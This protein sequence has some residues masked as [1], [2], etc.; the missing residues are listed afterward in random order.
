MKDVLIGG[1]DVGTSGCK[2]VLYDSEGRF[3]RDEYAEYD[4]LRK[5]GLHEVDVNV[6][7]NA[8]KNVIKA[9]DCRST[10]AIAITS[11][12]E[13][14]VMLD[15]NDKPCAPSMLYTDPRGKEQCS[16]LIDRFG[17]EK[18]AFKTGTKTHEMYSIPKIMWI[19]ENM[20]E[21]FKSTEKI[22][23]I[24]DYIVYMLCGVRQIDYSLAARTS[25]FDIE[26]KCW[27]KEILS[28]VG[29]DK[30]M[31]S[32]PVPT[33]TAAGRIKPEYADELGISVDTIIVCGANDQI[34]TMCGANIHTNEQVMDGTGT[35]ECVPVLFENLPEEYAFFDMGYSFVPHPNGGYACYAVS[36][37]GGATLKWFRSAFSDASYAELDK[38]V[39]EK[40]TNLLIMPHFAGAAT[41]YMDMT[42]K[43]TILGLTF[44]HTKFDIYK[45]LMEG[46][47][48]EIALNLEKMGFS[49][50][51]ITA[52]GGGARSDVWLQIKAD[53]LGI[54]VTALDCGE[55]GCAGTALMAGRAVGI[56]NENTMLSNTRKTFSP[57]VIKHEYYKKQL[58]KYKRIYAAA[59]K[60]MNNE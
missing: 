32:E 44:E 13:T 35:V 60:I 43:A 29:I 21:R 51:C 40:P 18:L 8:V 11:F 37:A 59:K 4:V 55:V 50:K 45:A 3:V 39:D 15:K 19:K 31:L 9:V 6:I 58:D 46:T 1:L 26:N 22:L 14:F 54:P 5:N 27:D 20:P 23:L 24:Q 36:Y 38:S 33:G 49:A 17:A 56:Y 57:N 48:Y 30:N 52:T 34:A 28:Y 53:V 47:A 25:G 42:S 2:I 12:G 7:F 10:A 16:M 41:P